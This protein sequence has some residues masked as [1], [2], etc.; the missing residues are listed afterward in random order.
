MNYLFLGDTHGDLYFAAQAA[1]MARDYNAEIIQVGDWGFLWPGGSSL[2]ALSKILVDHNVTMRFI[3][4]NHD[5]HPELKRRTPGRSE[6]EIAPKV[7]YQPRGS[8]DNGFL[9][10]GGAPSIDRHMRTPGKSWWPEETI[11]PEDMD[12]A[13]SHE[14][15]D[16]IVTHDAPD[17]PPGFAPLGDPAFRQ[18]ST[19][20][21]NDI[22]SLIRHYSPKLHV[23][24]HWHHRYTSGVTTGLDCNYGKFN[25][26]VMLWSP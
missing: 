13:L 9:F 18:K 25:S 2:D 4:G 16:V 8:T 12:A 6:T 19:Q 20:S 7:I 5:W 17:Y 15:I 14:N 24:G 3:D 23:H 1:E 22:R 26:A 21:M 11:T 10:L